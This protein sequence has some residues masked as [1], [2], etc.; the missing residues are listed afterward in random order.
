MGREPSRGLVMPGD[1]LFLR[2]TGERVR[3]VAVLDAAGTAIV[4]SE[5]EEFQATREELEWPWERHASC[6]CCG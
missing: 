5:A 2:T 1:E 3:V 4:R 6:V